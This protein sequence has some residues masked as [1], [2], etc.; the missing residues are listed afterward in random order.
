MVDKQ[1]SFVFTLRK[2]PFPRHIY[3]DL[4]ETSVLYF[5]CKTFPVIFYGAAVL[6]FVSLKV[7]TQVTQH[8]CGI[9]I[10]VQIL[11]KRQIYNN[12]KSLYLI[13]ST[14]FKWVAVYVKEC[15]LFISDN[16]RSIDA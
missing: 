10:A 6:N 11:F 9:V 15:V 2:F 4:L 5:T 16:V 8:S 7:E 14:S 12:R 1:T 13:F 3:P